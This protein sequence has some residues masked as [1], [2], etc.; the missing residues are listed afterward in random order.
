MKNEWKCLHLLKARFSK[1][2]ENITSPEL[3]QQSLLSQARIQ[4]P[5]WSELY[6]SKTLYDF[7]KKDN[8]VKQTTNKQQIMFINQIHSV[9]YS[10]MISARDTKEAANFIYHFA[11]LDAEGVKIR[12]QN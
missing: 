2:R 8:L 10:F 3:L 12:R 4:A 6:V 9:L 7:P 5:S 1:K 11:I